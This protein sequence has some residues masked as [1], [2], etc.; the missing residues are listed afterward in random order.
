[1]SDENFILDITLKYPYHGKTIACQLVLGRDTFQAL[2][3]LPK[4][5]EIPFYIESQKLAQEQL[6]E[7]QERLKWL[8]QII[9]RELE[10]MVSQQDTI[11]GYERNIY[12]RR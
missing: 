8:A 9:Q 12:E 7:R 11:N 4:D 2:Q 3:Q 1:M 6:K 5:R 10:K